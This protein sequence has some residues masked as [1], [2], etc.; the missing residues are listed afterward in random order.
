[1]SET[2]RLLSWRYAAKKMDATQVVPEEKVERI[3]EAIR[4]SASSSGLAA[5]RAPRPPAA[6]IQPVIT[7]PGNEDDVD[8][9]FTLKGHGAMK[10]ATLQV[11]DRVQDSPLS[12]SL[13][14]TVATRRRALGNE[15]Y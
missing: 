6:M 8:H 9:A 12:D 10:G 5:V 7:E 2:L 3:L 14:Q 11:F 4:L 15:R 13:L 1:M